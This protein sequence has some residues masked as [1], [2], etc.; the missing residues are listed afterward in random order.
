MLEN[1]YQAI[2]AVLDQLYLGLCITR[3]DNVV[4]VR[5]AMAERILFTHSA[6]KLAQDSRLICR[7]ADKQRSLEE[8]LLSA[9]SDES[10]SNHSNEILISN[11]QNC[12]Q[13]PLL[14][15]V[16]PLKDTSV[17]HEDTT[18][19]ALI[20]LLDPQQILKSDPTKTALVFG[21]TAAESAV[22]QMLVDGN[23]TS[24]IADQRGVSTETIKSQIKAVLRKCH[25][26]KRSDLI[27]QVWSLTS[28]MTCRMVASK[29]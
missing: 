24:D 29:Q 7:D 18:R 28:P 1:N 21:L 11:D 3:V 6:I 22:C 20:S 19:L 2:L 10:S 14:I 16:S 17:V 5:N 9:C 27:R 13:H 8:A 26:K 25:C 15:E 23:T 4:I 12:E